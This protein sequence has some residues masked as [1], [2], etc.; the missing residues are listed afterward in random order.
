MSVVHTLRER[1]GI[2]GWTRVNTILITVSI[3]GSLASICGLGVSLYVLR[4]ERVIQTE[5]EELSVRET[6]RHK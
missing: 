3:L 1:L 4:K 2:Y 6:E 5:V